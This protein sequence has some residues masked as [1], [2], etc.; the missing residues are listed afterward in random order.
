MRA[1]PRAQVTIATDTLAAGID[2]T[3]TED[4]VIARDALLTTATSLVTCSFITGLSTV[5]VEVEAAVGGGVIGVD[6]ADRPLLSSQS[7][8]FFLIARQKASASFCLSTE[9]SSNNSDTPLASN[10]LH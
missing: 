3:N 6:Q 9:A 7:F 1:G 8:A 4:V 2:A 5:A 10:A